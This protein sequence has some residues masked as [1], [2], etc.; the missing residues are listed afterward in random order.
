LP[1]DGMVVDDQ[2][3]HR[4]CHSGGHV[5]PS[6]PQARYLAANFFGTISGQSGTFRSVRGYGGV[7]LRTKTP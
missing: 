6:I 2:A 7:G 3:A 4:A 1:H 5:R